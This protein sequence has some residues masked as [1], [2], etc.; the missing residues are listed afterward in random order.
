MIFLSECKNVG[1][2]FIKPSASWLFTLSLL[3]SS[4]KIPLGSARFK[5]YLLLI[6]VISFVHRNAHHAT[7][8]LPLKSLSILTFLSSCEILRTSQLL[9]SLF[10][11]LV[12]P[13]LNVI[14]IFSSF[15]VYH[16]LTSI[17]Y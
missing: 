1:A 14:L 6:S 3:K 4:T 13:A 15:F 9:I 10:I 11:C 2:K 16:I 17:I 8:L 12:N 5:P 7:T